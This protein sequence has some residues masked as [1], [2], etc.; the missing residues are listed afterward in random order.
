MLILQKTLPES[1]NS[2]PIYA[3]REGSKGIDFLALDLEIYLLPLTGK[4]KHKRDDL[5]ENLYQNI[6]RSSIYQAIPES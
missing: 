3:H 6:D 1:Q 5:L 2:M 4:R